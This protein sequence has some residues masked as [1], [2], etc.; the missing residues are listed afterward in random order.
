MY[1]HIRYAAFL[2][3]VTFAF[4][5]LAPQCPGQEPAWWTKQKKDCG[6]PSNLAYNSWDGSCPAQSQ[7][8]GGTTDNG[9]AG[10]QRQQ[11]IE[12]ER[13]RQEAEQKRLE[14]AKEAKRIADQKVF[15]K[16]RD[17]AAGTLRGSGGN[18]TIKTTTENGL[19]GS[20]ANTGIRTGSSGTTPFRESEKFYALQLRKYEAL[21][22][23]GNPL[24]PAI[25]PLI[26]RG[27][28]GGMTWTFGF[29]RPPANCQGVCMERFKADVKRQLALYCSKEKD[30]ELCV[31]EPP[32]TADLYDMVISMASTHSAVEDLA[33]RV[34]WD[35]SAY[36]EFSRQHK[37]I[38]VGL[39]DRHFDTL[40]CHS[41]GAMLCL[42]ALRSGETT[43][44]TVRLFGPQINPAAAALWAELVKKGVR[45]EI[46]IN[47][48]DP[49]PAAAWKQP[50]KRSAVTLGAESA[51]FTNPMSGPIVLAD[52]LINTFRDSKAQVLDKPLERYGFFVTRFNCSEVPTLIDFHC[53]S[54]REYEDG[55]A[56][57]QASKYK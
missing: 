33:L 50:T 45:V 25:P 19:R 29:K 11:R 39:K 52:I 49:V 43:A 34:I 13:Q 22:D 51:W 41:N 54:M 35:G 3:V 7:N 2:I 24:D 37:E 47:N 17:E 44:K 46:Y 32:F 21:D 20:T 1:G 15:E 27:L 42:A 8:T 12:E 14:A 53:H 48:G 18:P 38:F 31:K 56:R 16:N 23:G 55:L 40:D 57:A 5:V 26:G 4:C 30:P 36:G 28:V 6:L 10:R 9:E